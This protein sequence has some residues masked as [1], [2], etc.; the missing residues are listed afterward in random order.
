MER[1]DARGGKK[2]H[3]KHSVT[4]CICTGGRR[5]RFPRS[6]PLHRAGWVGFLLEGLREEWRSVQGRARGRR[7]RGAALVHPCLCQICLLRSFFSPFPSWAPSRAS[8]TQTAGG[9]RR[10]GASTCRAVPCVCRACPN[11]SMT[12]E[13][14]ALRS[15][16]GALENPRFLI[17]AVVV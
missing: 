11:P 9:G 14:P 4:W 16:L 1:D 7:R 8:H 15:L 5:T 17:H 2:H 6:V 10:A 3:N 13:P 12:H